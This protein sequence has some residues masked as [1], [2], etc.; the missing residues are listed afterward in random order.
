MALLK[1]G[2]SFVFGH[3]LIVVI[4]VVKADNAEIYHPKICQLLFGGSNE[5]SWKSARQR[6]AT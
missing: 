3:P 2:V 5:L 6:L 1:Y 4:K